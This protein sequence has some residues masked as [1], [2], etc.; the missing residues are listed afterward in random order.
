EKFADDE[1]VGL[2]LAA[3]RGLGDLGGSTAVLQKHVKDEELDVRYEAR[4][5]LG[6]Q[7]HKEALGPLALEAEDML[8]DP[9]GARTVSKELEDNGDRYSQYLLG[10]ALARLSDPR[11][12]KIVE[13]TIL[14]EKPWESKHFLRLGAADGLGRQC[15]RTGKPVPAKIIAGLGHEHTE[16]RLACVRAVAAAKSAQNLTRLSHLLTDPQ[17]DVRHEA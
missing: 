3:V 12:V 11:A 14:K 8:S 4:G 10:L 5:A 9:R 16:V 7:G 2:R 13:S 1:D 15:E 17:L 6:S